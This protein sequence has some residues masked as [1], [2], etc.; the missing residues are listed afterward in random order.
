EKDVGLDCSPH[1]GIELVQDSNS[2][3]A[4]CRN[5]PV[6]E[7]TM[8]GLVSLLIDHGGGVPHLLEALRVRG[9]E[10]REGAG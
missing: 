1:E 4:G 10:W 8:D 5:C 3:F 2:G 7:V 9:G 6:S